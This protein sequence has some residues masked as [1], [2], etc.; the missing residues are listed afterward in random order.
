[1]D[2]QTQPVSQGS[3]IVFQNTALAYITLTSIVTELTVHLWPRLNG[4]TAQLQV[5]TANQ[6]V[7]SNS[8]TSKQTT[9]L[10]LMLLYLIQL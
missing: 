3:K 10:A 2:I 1:M 6:T 9:I 7:A 5:T 4:F 8:K